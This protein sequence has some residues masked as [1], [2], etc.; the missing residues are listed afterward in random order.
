VRHCHQREQQQQQQQHEQ[1]QHE[2][3]QQQQQRG[4]QQSSAS[5]ALRSVAN[6][7]AS[8]GAPLAHSMGKSIQAALQRA[9]TTEV[10]LTSVAE[11]RALCDPRVHVK[12]TS[13]T[14]SDVRAT[15]NGQRIVLELSKKTA[16]SWRLYHYTLDVDLTSLV[17]RSGRP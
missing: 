12:V 3:Q 10:Q 17:R 14:D 16:A 7:S 2:Q 11:A 13:A 5:T 6:M 15:E 1:Q 4:D 8:E 9:V